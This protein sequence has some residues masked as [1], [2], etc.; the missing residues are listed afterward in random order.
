MS[1]I[2]FFFICIF[3]CMRMNLRAMIPQGSAGRFCLLEIMKSYFS[4][5]Q[6]CTKIIKMLTFKAYFSQIRSQLKRIR[7]QI[8][9]NF[10]VSNWKSSHDVN[11]V[12]LVMC[13]SRQYH[14]A[15]FFY[16]RMCIHRST[17]RDV[18]T[19]IIVL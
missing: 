7:S 11:D 17:T 2:S 15:E 1:Y 9:S 3:H 14:F 10:Y 6:Q 8:R 13:Q 19:T 5:I 12:M 18:T 16:N 4:Y